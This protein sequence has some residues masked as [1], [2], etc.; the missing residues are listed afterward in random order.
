MPRPKLSPLQARFAA[1]LAATLILLIASP[2]ALGPRLAHAIDTDSISQIDHN[3]PIP[4]THLDFGELEPRD[5]PVIIDD[6]AADGGTE[7]DGGEAGTRPLAEFAL[8]N[9]VLKKDNVR[10]GETRH[11]YFPK[12]S[13]N[14]SSTTSRTRSNDDES[15]GSESDDSLLNVENDVAV[16]ETRATTVYVTANTC[17]QP[18]LSATRMAQD[19]GA[20]QLRLYISQSEKFQEPGPG[21]D[22]S[23][24]T[25]KN[26]TDGYAR[27]DLPAGQDVYIGVAALNTSRYTGV[28]NYEIAASFDEP[29]H[30]L[31]NK[32]PGLYFVDGDSNAALLVTKAMTEEHEGEE[33]DRW[34]NMDT[35]PY[36]MFAHSIND[37][38]IIGLHNS[39]CGLRMNAQVKKKHDN[40]GV[41]MASRGP[42]NLP[43]QQFY[44][45]KLNA[46][47]SYYG[48]MVQ[49]PNSTLK[50]QDG[51][52]VIG[53]GGRLW[54]PMNFTT[55]RGKHLHTL[56]LT[57]FQ[58]H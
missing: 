55:K 6:D 21:I 47:S 16:S 43:K 10:I 15:G 3:H 54:K 35:P 20:P 27:V 40:V 9:N 31:E 28:Y 25:S 56:S 58:N 26:F 2:F 45:N 41:G 14:S 38:A 52:G 12:E 22:D 11:W 37:S 17:L 57:K 23:A 29:F 36:T 30:S 49:E 5:V 34:M 51:G 42:D 50:R 8:E 4:H 24:V 53:G 46:S 48:F 33:Y 32:N 1:T 19:A 39:Y 18:D 44:I 7:R 13:H